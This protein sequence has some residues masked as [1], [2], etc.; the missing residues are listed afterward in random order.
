[1]QE[2]PLTYWTFA[3]VVPP[4][5]T[6]TP[7]SGWNADVSSAAPAPEHAAQPRITAA[8]SLFINSPSESED[9][10]ISDPPEQSIL[11]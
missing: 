11:L 2:L 7:N 5:V 4:K 1:L 3:K 10:V 9:T 8:N 6:P